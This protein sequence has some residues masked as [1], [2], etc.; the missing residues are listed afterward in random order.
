[1][2]KSTKLVCNWQTPASTCSPHL[3]TLV[4]FDKWLMPKHKEHLAKNCFLKLPTTWNHIDFKEIFLWR[5]SGGNAFKNPETRPGGHLCSKEVL[6]NKENLKIYL[7]L[8]IHQSYQFW[9]AIF[10]KEATIL[11]CKVVS[12]WIQRKTPVGVFSW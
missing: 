7:I 11:S 2:R 5:F 3:K 10:I 1:M 9:V 6:L 12:D 4:N 8:L